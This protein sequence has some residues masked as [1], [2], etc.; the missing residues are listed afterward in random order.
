MGWSF[1]SKI[2]FRAGL[3][4]MYCLSLVLSWNILFSTYI[5]IENSAGCNNLGWHPLSLGR[6]SIQDLLASIVPMEKSGEI[7]MLC[8]YDT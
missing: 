4:D 5:L 3:V 6:I 7:L 1:P 8:L 2:F